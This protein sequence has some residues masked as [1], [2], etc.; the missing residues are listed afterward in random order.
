MREQSNTLKIVSAVAPGTYTADVAPVSIDRQGFGS[1]TFAIHVGVGGITFTGANKIE[2]VLEESYDGTDWTDVLAKDI[3]GLDLSA[4]DGRVLALKTAH[5]A[6]TV[7][8]FGYIGD[9]RFI[10]LTTDFS[11]THSTPTPLSALAIFGRPAHAP[12]T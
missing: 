6:P 5:A 7:T 1:A 9:A 4:D 12:V 2:F 10:R 11:G 3:V 8:K